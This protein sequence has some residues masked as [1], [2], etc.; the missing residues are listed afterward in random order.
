MLAAVKCQSDS[1]VEVA[2]VIEGG[3][4]LGIVGDDIQDYGDGSFSPAPGVDTVC[5]FPKNVARCKNSS[6]KDENYH[7]VCLN[8]NPVVVVVVLCF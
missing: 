5:V 1:E 8:M 7:A 4:D 6:I 2:E 3:G